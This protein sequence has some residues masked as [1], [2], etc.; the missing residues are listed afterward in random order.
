MLDKSKF[1]LCLLRY[2]E[3]LL[4]GLK[5]YITPKSVIEFVKYGP[6]LICLF[7]GLNIIDTYINMFEAKI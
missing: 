6:F 7:L 2:G 5:I 3:K 4:P 1:Y